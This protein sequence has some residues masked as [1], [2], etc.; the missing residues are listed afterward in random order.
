MLVDT[1]CH[2]H[3][4]A[5]DDDRDAVIRRAR[6]ARVHMITVGTD[7][8]TSEAAVKLASAHNDIWATVGLHPNHLFPYPHDTDEEPAV[9]VEQF[10][11]EIYRAL[12]KQD[13]VRAIGEC[14]LDFY[15][16]PE[17]LDAAQVQKTQE[18]VFR[19]HLDLANELQLPVI[20]HCRDAHGAVRRI[21][22]EYVASGKLLRRG[23][24]H[25]FTG[26]RA[27][28]E[29]Y[30]PLGFS[31]SFTGII[32]FPPRKGQTETVSDV[33]RALPLEQI[34]IETDAP[35]LAPVPHRGK[36]NEPAYV[37]F[38]AQKIAEIQQTSLHEVAAVTTKNAEVLFGLR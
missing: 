13:T 17:N 8:A 30:L 23:V 27:E 7:R 20:I 12:A 24:I 29:A 25:C 28:A 15:R 26:T 14:G 22:S 38:V 6:E 1:H 21:L 16:I 10:D 11:V 35:Y 32:T 36:R 31:I 2:I 34:L 18:E 5:Y 3:F 33:V 9:T 4:R 37:Q 19:S